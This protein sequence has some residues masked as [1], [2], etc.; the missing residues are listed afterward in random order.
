MDIIGISPYHH[1]STQ[2]LVSNDQF[3]AAAQKVWFCR[4]KHDAGF[5]H[6]AIRYFHNKPR[7]ST[8]EINGIVNYDKPLGNFKKQLETHLFYSHKI[9]KFLLA[10]M[11]ALLKQKLY[12]QSTPEIKSHLYYA[13]SFSN[14]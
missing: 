14:G 2:T 12:L 4:K 5:S 9:F 13:D 7:N 1:H 10:T 3:S 6:H 11:P 8:T